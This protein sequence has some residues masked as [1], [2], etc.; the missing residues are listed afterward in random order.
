MYQQLAL[1]IVTVLDWI[2]TMASTGDPETLLL[3]DPGFNPSQLGTA[4]NNVHLPIIGPHYI[5]LQQ[6]LG[7]SVLQYYEGAATVGG[8]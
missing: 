7:G 1:H 3:G 5:F 6:R 2:G 4:R 8:W